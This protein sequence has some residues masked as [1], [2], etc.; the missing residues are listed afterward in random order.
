MLDD[1]DCGSQSVVINRWLDKISQ[2]RERKTVK[3]T[4]VT[5]EL[6]ERVI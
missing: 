5:V 6:V 1:T 2:F 4:I 3:F